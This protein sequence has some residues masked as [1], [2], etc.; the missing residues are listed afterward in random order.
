MRE[1]DI[2]DTV[3]WGKKCLVKVNARKTKVVFV[4]RTGNSSSIDVKMDVKIE[5]K[6]PLIYDFHN[7]CCHRPPCPRSF[8][9]VKMNRDLFLPIHSYTGKSE[10]KTNSGRSSEKPISLNCYGNLLNM[11]L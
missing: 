1:Y 2:I 8:L 7:S 5:I 10:G 4:S 3:D 6:F 9:E 11:L